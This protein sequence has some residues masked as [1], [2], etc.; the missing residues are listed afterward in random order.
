MSIIVREM[1]PEDYD[2]VYA[3]W[4]SIQGFG[5]RTMDDSREGVERF[6]R[7]N[8][9]TSVVAEQNG[10]IVGAILCGHDG[11]RGCFYHVCVAKE[12]R[13]HGAGHLMAQFAMRAL[14]REGINK[15]NLI[16]F[17]SNE[18]GN[19]FWSGVGWTQREDLNYYD[20]TLNEENITNF[21]K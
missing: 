6:L 1:T 10:R 13:H 19:A 16:A 12:Y 14:R 11:R 18:I 9:T 4:M 3:L 15:V 21:I 7:R 2:S 20:Y 8:P 17:K 5:I